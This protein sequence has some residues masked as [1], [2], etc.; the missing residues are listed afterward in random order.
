M[1]SEI[2]GVARFT[3]DAKL[4]RTAGCRPDPAFIPSGG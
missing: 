3:N 1:L 4:A 2:A